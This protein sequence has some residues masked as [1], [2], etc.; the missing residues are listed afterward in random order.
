MVPGDEHY[1]AAR[2]GSGGRGHVQ[3]GP[4]Q[5]PG[6]WRGGEEWAGSAEMRLRPGEHQRGRFV[7]SKKIHDGPRN[8]TGP[9]T[10]EQH[11]SSFRFPTGCLRGLFPRGA[12]S[13]PNGG[14]TPYPGLCVRYH[15]IDRLHAEFTGRA[16]SGRHAAEIPSYCWRANPHR[17]V[18]RTGFRGAFEDNQLSS[19][20]P[21]PF[22]GGGPRGATS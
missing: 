16:I 14:E 5:R 1:S 19:R 22:C 10:R 6:W 18:I 2:S 3:S 8:L 15:V 20:V 21:G 7:K 13:P 12:Q 4:P 11:T 17:P 9:V